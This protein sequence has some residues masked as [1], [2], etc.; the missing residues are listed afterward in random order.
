MAC[1]HRI[2]QPCTPGVSM[3]TV[4]VCT[5]TQETS[6][7]SALRFVRLHC[8]PPHLRLSTVAAVL[9]CSTSRAQ[10]GCAQAC[11]SGLSQGSVRT[12]SI[13]TCSVRCAQSGALKI[14]HLLRDRRWPA[15]PM[16]ILA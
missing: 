3:M 6:A 8:G 4:S 16:R 7:R 14:G 10:S 15:A 1:T 13:R 2:G 9:I 5:C 11:A 12:C